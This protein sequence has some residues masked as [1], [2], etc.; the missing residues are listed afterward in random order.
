MI[1]P[2]RNGEKIVIIFWPI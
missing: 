2:N 1:N